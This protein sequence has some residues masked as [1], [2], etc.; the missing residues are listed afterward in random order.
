MIYPET[1]QWEAKQFMYRLVITLAV[2]A[3]IFLLSSC[4]TYT[5][6][7]THPEG[8]HVSQPRIVSPVTFG[9][10][11]VSGFVVF[12]NQSKYLLPGSDQHDWNKITGLSHS[13]VP[14]GKNVMFA[15]RYLPE[16][17]SFSVGWYSNLSGNRFGEMVRTATFDTVFFSLEEKPG[18][19]LFIASGDSALVSYPAWSN[20][21]YP[22]QPWFGGN[23]AGPINVSYFLHLSIN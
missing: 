21:S 10:H 12:T 8:K 14:D 1:P 19:C 16:I 17:D 15:W 13:I 23:R 6:T 7:I 11:S 2:I 18:H 5:G 4:H 20:I 22:R 9:K 3:S